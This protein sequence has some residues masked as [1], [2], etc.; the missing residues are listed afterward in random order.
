MNIKINIT[1]FSTKRNT[2]ID[3]DIWAIFLNIEEVMDLV[4]NC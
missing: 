2:T 4:F 1:F 3:T